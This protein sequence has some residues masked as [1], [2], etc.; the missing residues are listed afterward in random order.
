MKVLV[1]LFFVL[2]LTT[3]YGQ[4]GINKKLVGKWQQLSQAN[5]DS[6]VIEKFDSTLQIFYDFKSDGSFLYT[7]IRNDNHF[8]GTYYTI[9]R[10]KV[11]KGNELILYQRRPEPKRPN[12]TYGDAEYSIVTIK[13][14]TL[15]LYGKFS[16]DSEGGM[17]KALFKKQ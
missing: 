5:Q 16:V 9:G 13:T 11:V 17:G 12:T 6:S 8:K 4:T 10:W 1:T 2:L 3:S 7:H 14:S 15:I